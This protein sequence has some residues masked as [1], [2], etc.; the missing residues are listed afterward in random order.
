VATISLKEEIG[1]GKFGILI[2]KKL[3]QRPEHIG[4]L[5]RKYTKMDLT[6]KNHIHYFPTIPESLIDVV[7]IIDMKGAKYDGKVEGE[8]ALTV[9]PHGMGSGVFIGG[10]DIF[11]NKFRINLSRSHEEEKDYCNDFWFLRLLATKNHT[12]LW[13]KNRLVG[14]TV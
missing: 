3:P 9:R 14:K 13:L 1:R 8:Y 7:R 5:S 2:C 4:A 6:T 11:Y 10:C 12:N